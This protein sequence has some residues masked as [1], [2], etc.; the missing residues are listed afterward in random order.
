MRTNEWKKTLAAAA[1]VALLA[2]LAASARPPAQRPAPQLKPN[3][4][5]ACAVDSRRGP[6]GSRH[7]HPGPAHGHRP[8]G[9]ASWYWAPPPPPPPPPYW[10]YYPPPPPPPPPPPAYYYYYRPG[11]SVSFSF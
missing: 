8:H 11:W 4:A 7:P 9:H 3:Q 10:G 2:P 1:V 6:S 5:A